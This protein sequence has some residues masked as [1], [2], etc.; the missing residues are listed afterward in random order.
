MLK[1]VK[2]MII[3]LF[4][5]VAIFAFYYFFFLSTKTQSKLSIYSW[6]SDEI[7][8]PENRRELIKVL[9]E[10]GF[11]R[12]F[13]SISSEISEQEIQSFVLEL[14]GQNI[15]V[16]A[17]SGTPEWALDPTGESMIERLKR[18]A[19]INEQLPKNQQIKGMVIDVEPYL[20]DDFDWENELIQ[21]SFISGMKNLYHVAQ[22][23]ELELIV[24]VPYFYD[25]KGY[26]EVLSTI[27]HEASS[28][29]AVMN[30]FRNREINHLTF[31]ASEAKKA[32]KPLT[33]VYEFKP[34]GK[35]GLSEKNTY[36][37][38]GVLAAQENAKQLI[39]HYDGQT[40]HIAFHDYRAFREVIQND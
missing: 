25:T 30:Y 37:N 2:I 16:Y 1:V 40:I 14:T 24:V 28:E 20:L 29:V 6:S 3:F 12:I 31:E 11:N 9:D 26:Q 34:P 13:Q 39:E 15:D 7:T 21:E 38:E 19:M 17:L 36:Y 5:V 32:N 23:E 22:E 33:S 8:I 35:H 4:L 27:I 18:I 10:Y